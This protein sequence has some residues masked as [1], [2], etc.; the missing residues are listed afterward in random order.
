MTDIVPSL[1]E[2]I[3]EFCSRAKLLALCRIRR[4]GALPSSEKLPIVKVVLD[5]SGEKCLGSTAKTNFPCE[6]VGIWA[7]RMN[8]IESSTNREKK[9]CS[10]INLATYLGRCP[11]AACFSVKS[12]SNLDHKSYPPVL[13][14]ALPVGESTILILRTVTGLTETETTIK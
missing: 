14:S 8:A 4:I 3:R 10:I 1:L 2:N 11:K 12:P 6:G 9:K 5:K 13:N 7:E